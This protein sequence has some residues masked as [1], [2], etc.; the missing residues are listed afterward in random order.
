MAGRRKEKVREAKHALYRQLVLEGAERVFAEKGYED[1][2]MEEIARESGL[3]LGTLYSVF[4]GK[5]YVFRALHESADRELLRR[6]AECVR[7]VEDPLEAV[8]AGVRAYT[9]Y[10]LQHPDFLRMH[11]REGLAW[12]TA[13]AGG[14][15]RQRTEA[16]RSGV[17]MLSR[18]FERCIQAGVFVE[19]DPALQ[20]RMMVAMQQVQLA[21]WIET[22]ME[23]P[24]DDLVREMTEQVK[25]AFGRDPETA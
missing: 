10:F 11:L 7:G 23:R 16:W 21:H 4:S 13:E 19:G 18:A 15:S 2:K 17:D 8:L 6:A 14:H 22:G 3:S 5:A 20:A 25:R 1:A 12:G 24:P 9:E